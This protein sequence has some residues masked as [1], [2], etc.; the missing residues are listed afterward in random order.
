MEEE[1][2]EDDDMALGDILLDDVLALCDT[3]LHGRQVLD[4]NASCGTLVLDS[5][6]WNSALV[7]HDILGNYDIQVLGNGVLVHR[8]G[9]ISVCNVNPQA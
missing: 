6:V 5:E 1:E 8:G 3:V 9:Q 4:G 2:E 7:S